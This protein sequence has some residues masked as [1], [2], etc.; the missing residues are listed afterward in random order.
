MQAGGK[1]GVSRHPFAPQLYL[2]WEPSHKA[3]KDLAT[4]LMTLEPGPHVLQQPELN[5]NSL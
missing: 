5:Y 3:F 2:S 1:P 4:S